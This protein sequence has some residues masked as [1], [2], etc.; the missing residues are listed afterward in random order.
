MWKLK[1]ITKQHLL[2]QMQKYFNNATV[3]V[4]MEWRRYILVLLPGD[5]K[6]VG[7]KCNTEGGQCFLSESASHSLSRWL[8]QKNHLKGS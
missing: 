4:S 3:S 6:R 5:T 7:R 1:I 2:I 8:W